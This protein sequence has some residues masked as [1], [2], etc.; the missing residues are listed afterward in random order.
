VDQRNETAVCLLRIERQNDGILITM[1]VTRDIATGVQ[2]PPRRFVDAGSAVDAIA[3][4]L[5]D[6]G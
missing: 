1:L 2:D 4:F 5:D 3:A 6:V